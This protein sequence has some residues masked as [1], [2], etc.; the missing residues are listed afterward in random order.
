MWGSTV[1]DTRTN[2]PPNTKRLQMN[3]AKF[4]QADGWEKTRPHGS[5][6]RL[7]VYTRG[8]NAGQPDPNGNKEP[9]P[10]AFIRN[11]YLPLKK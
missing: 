4:M 2:A 5:G 1:L 10:D 3:I 8:P 11:K 7:T 9:D 6:S